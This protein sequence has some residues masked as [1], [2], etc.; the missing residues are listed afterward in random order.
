MKIYVAG[1]ITNSDPHLMRANVEA[2]MKVGC[3]LFKLGHEPFVPHT[4]YF[5]H[6]YAQATGIYVPT[7]EDWMRL[8]LVMLPIFEAVLRLPG[9]SKGADM[10]VL[11]ANRLG[12]PVFHDVPSLLAYAATVDKRG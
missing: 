4:S 1:P 10:E 11:R 3:E 9:T 2:A 12:I 8:D 6:I 5:Q 7:W